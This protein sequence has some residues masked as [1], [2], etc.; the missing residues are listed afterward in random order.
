M[1]IEIRHRCANVLLAIVIG[2]LGA[3]ALVHW[4]AQ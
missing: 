1:Q 2:I 3:L 4:W